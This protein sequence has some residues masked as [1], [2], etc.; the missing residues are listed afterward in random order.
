[1]ARARAAIYRGQEIFNNKQFTIAGVNGLND[2]L[3][4][5]SIV[6]TC[7]TCHNTPNVGGHSTYAVFDIGTADEGA[8]SEDFPLITLQ[9]KTTMATR[10]TCD[11]GRGGGT[12]L[13]KDIG[14]FRAPPLRG[15]AARAPYFHDG[16][17]R[18]LE[19][20][21]RHHDQRFGIGLNHFEKHDLEAFLKA[22]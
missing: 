15:L 4:M 17:A 5:P 19:A 21:I 20:V 11:M 10:T 3:N 9:H 12:G 1:V 7:T 2:R 14:G 13:W 6:G 8:C 18:D 16:G 22:L